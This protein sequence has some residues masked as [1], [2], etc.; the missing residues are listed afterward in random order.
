MHLLFR[1]ITVGHFA[2][3]FNKNIFQYLTNVFIILW[4]LSW[5]RKFAFN[6]NNIAKIELMIFV[7]FWLVDRMGSG[8][9]S[10]KSSSIGA[11]SSAGRNRRAI[12]LEGADD[13]PYQVSNPK[14][15]GEAALRYEN[16][17]PS[18]LVSIVTISLE[19]SWK[20]S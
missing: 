4:C 5:W 3:Y 15:V 19:I 1:I 14:T 13:K 6:I 12:N 10:R 8:T 17:P 7:W 9:G 20:F 2:Q 11:R 18:S 16:T